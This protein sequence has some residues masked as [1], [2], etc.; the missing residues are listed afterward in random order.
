MFQK[1]L[2]PYKIPLQHI[3]QSHVLKVGQGCPITLFMTGH[4]LMPHPQKAKTVQ[5]IVSKA[6]SF[7]PI[8]ISIN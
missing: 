1:I 4:C 3:R 2:Q 8:K 7:I 6:V 5:R